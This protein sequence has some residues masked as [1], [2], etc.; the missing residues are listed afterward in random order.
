MATQTGIT[1][2]APNEPFT[3]VNTI[4]RTTPGP[5]QAL[6]KSLAVGINPVY[7]PSLIQAFHPPLI[8]PPGP[9]NAPFNPPN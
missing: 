3:I 4:P 9:S 5:T 6:V 8:I 2:S 1:I 7:V